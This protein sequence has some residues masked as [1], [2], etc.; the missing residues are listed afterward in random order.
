MW[1]GNLKYRVISILYLV[2]T[3][4]SAE[5]AEFFLSV[6][7]SFQHARQVPI[8]L[9]IQFLLFIMPNDTNVFELAWWKGPGG[10]KIR[11][12]TLAGVPCE[13]LQTVGPT[14]RPAPNSCVSPGAVDSRQIRLALL[15]SEVAG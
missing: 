3:L 6:S 8:F 4:E 10:G 14:A 9:H 12:I 13:I 5:A 1:D 11:R 15:T 2:Y 7:F